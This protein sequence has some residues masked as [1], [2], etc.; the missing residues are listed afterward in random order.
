MTSSAQ[1]PVQDTLHSG[2]LSSQTLSAKWPQ[3]S[4]PWCFW[5]LGMCFRSCGVFWQN[6]LVCPWGCHKNGKYFPQVYLPKWGCT[7]GQGPLGPQD[8]GLI[9]ISGHSQAQAFSRDPLGRIPEP[10]ERTR[11]TLPRSLWCSFVWMQIALMFHFLYLPWFLCSENLLFQPPP[12]FPLWRQ[13]TSASGFYQTKLG[14]QD[15]Q[16]HSAEWACH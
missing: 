12:P 13:F 15:S 1:G 16:P 5:W 8:K 11:G 4:L 9:Q 7:F 10:A 14:F 2:L 3:K 6:C